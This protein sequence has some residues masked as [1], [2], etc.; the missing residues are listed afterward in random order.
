MRQEISE[1]LA[2]IQQ[3]EHGYRHI[4]DAA[5]KIIASHE[6]KECQALAIRL[7]EHGA[8]QVRMLAVAILGRSARMDICA[9]DFLKARVSLDDNW[10]VQEMLAKAFDEVCHTRGYAESLPLIREWLGSS[11]PNTIRAVI[12]GLRVWTSRPF[13]AQYPAIAIELIS[14]HKAH[15]SEYLRRSVGNALKD[16]AKKHTTLVLQELSRWDL[17]DPK[18]A[19]THR[20]ATKH[21]QNSI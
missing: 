7:F 1:I 16:I 15:E 21:I 12:E 19:F 3:I 11:H 13:F 18:V 5:E 6:A 10:R 9:L 20:L 2:Q 8:Y 17:S 4:Y 14:A